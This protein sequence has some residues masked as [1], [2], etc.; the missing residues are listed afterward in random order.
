[1]KKIKLFIAELCVLAIL[2]VAL[3]FFV[4]A[5]EEG[6]D[7]MENLADIQEQEP[8][9]AEDQGKVI[10]NTEEIL[11]EADSEANI[12]RQAG[13]M[14][15]AMT[16]EE[17]V[18]QM[19]FVTPESLT[20]VS[21]VTAAG[22]TTDAA[23]TD[24]PVGGIVYFEAN[25]VNPQQTKQ[26]LSHVQ[27]YM[28]DKSG[29]PIFLGV[30]E[31][32]GRVA[33][34][35]NNSAFGVEKVEAMGT[36]AKEGDGTKICQ[37][38]KIIGGYLKELGFNVDFAPDADVLTNPDNQVIGSR[39]F[40]TDASF[41]SDMAWEYTKGLHEEGI[42]ASYKHFPGHGGTSED[43]H[44][45]YAYSHKS[46]EELKQ[47]ELVPFSL[48][49]K[50]GVDFIMVSHISTPEASGDDTPASLS[51]FWV[52]DILR[53]EMGYEGIIITDSL[54]I[55]LPWSPWNRQ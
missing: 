10:V 45:G 40:G 48:G 3:V 11:G 44:S 32:G 27:E 53:N 17:K 16:L 19:F 20:G 18:G 36:L 50:K 8:N 43:S 21:K 14:L 26:M 5:E 9:Q 29:F 2:A 35:A 54:A 39:S 34:I 51:K 1:M 28:T 6:T 31:E 23:L 7:T 15:S 42:L 49:A 38:G 46:L 4:R 12:A 52:T 25:L 55:T 22:N 24:Y 13:Q 41:V 47:A 37:A 33:R 30:D